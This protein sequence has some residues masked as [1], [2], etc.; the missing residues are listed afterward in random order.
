MLQS[1]RVFL[2]IDFLYFIVYNY[3]MFNYILFDLDGTIT[4]P[5][6]GI[7]NC[8]KY[9]LE[10]LGVKVPDIS[11]LSCFI[12]PPLFEQFKAFAGFDDDKASEAVKKY[13]ERYSVTGW[14]ECTLTEG[15]ETLLKNLKK[16][17]KTTALATCK[18]EKYAKMILEYFDIAKYFDFIGGAEL[19]TK[20]RSSKKDVIEY[21]L[22]NLHLTEKDKPKAVIIGDTLY[23]IEG[24]KAAG[25]SS[26]GVLSGY[27][28]RSELEE[29]GADFIADSMNDIND[30]LN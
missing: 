13:R 11:A 14:K 12:G 27:G 5:F 1:I 8:A 28:T 22:D 23:D 10:S 6:E 17:G 21:V 24:A 20:G 7:T 3:I 26:I 9:V 15:T 2:I 4:D 29:H 16:M 30:L 19:D 25:I 18:P